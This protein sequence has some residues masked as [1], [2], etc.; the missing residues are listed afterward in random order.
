MRKKVAGP[1]RGRAA[2]NRKPQATTARQPR[3]LAHCHHLADRQSSVIVGITKCASKIC[4][5]ASRTATARQPRPLAHC[6][7]RR[8]CLALFSYPLYKSSRAAKISGDRN[9]WPTGA[10]KYEGIPSVSAL[11]WLCGPTRVIATT[12]YRRESAV[13]QWADKVCHF[14]AIRT[15][16][17]NISARKAT[18][19]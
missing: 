11:K 16:T 14:R 12:G 3:A 6:P 10:T 5:M 8:P 4:V 17:S 19:L 15:R 13:T 18:N 9:T 1:Y 7:F 2:P